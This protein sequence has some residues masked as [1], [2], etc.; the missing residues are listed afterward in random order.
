M[1]LFSRKKRNQFAAKSIT[2]RREESKKG[3]TVLWIAI[4]LV[5]LIGAASLAEYIHQQHFSVDHISIRRQVETEPHVVPEDQL[6]RLTDPLKGSSMVLLDESRLEAEWLSRFPSIESIDIVR[7]FPNELEVRY[8]PKVAYTQLVASDSTYLVDRK[9]FVFAEASLSTVPTLTTDSVEIEIGK[10]T[11]AK[12]VKLGLLL[13]EGLRGIEP[14]LKE[15]IL[16][17]QE[18]EVVLA[19]QP[20]IL[21]S[22]D[23][24]AEVVIAE[25]T[26]LLHKFAK[27]ES[28]PKEVDLRYQRPVLRY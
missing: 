13:V 2:P 15:I 6:A 8:I 10:V 23:R 19:R 11:S 9:G 5:L 7:N 12:G 20:K 28:Y 1:A 25:L 14:T 22:V 17:Q 27:D 21:V 4:I 16:R 24:N 26:S 3:R 18:L